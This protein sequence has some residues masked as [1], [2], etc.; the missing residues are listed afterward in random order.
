MPGTETPGKPEP[1]VIRIS[2]KRVMDLLYIALVAVVLI[3]VYLTYPR[4]TPDDSKPRI[5]HEIWQAV[6]PATSQPF[7]RIKATR[8]RSTG[9]YKSPLTIS[10]KDTDDT[11]WTFKVPGCAPSDITTDHIK[12]DGESA[13]WV[14]FERITLDQIPK[15]QRW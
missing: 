14:T 7:I 12:P 10:I 5:E 2:V 3:I 1:N 6:K 8:D 9:K 11:V 13:G 15:N 4:S